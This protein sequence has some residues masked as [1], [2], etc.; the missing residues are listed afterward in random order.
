MGLGVVTV[1]LEHVLRPRLEQ[2]L[3][4]LTPYGFPFPWVVYTDSALSSIYQM[5]WLGFLVDVLIWSL[6]FFVVVVIMVRRYHFRYQRGLD[7]KRNAGV[8]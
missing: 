4:V 2:S 5:L 6:L 3:P 8:R 1:L 7:L